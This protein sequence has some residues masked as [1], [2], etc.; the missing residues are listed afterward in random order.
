MHSHI[1][2]NLLSSNRHLAMSLVIHCE[3]L[4][5]TFYDVNIPN[6]LQCTIKILKEVYDMIKP[7]VEQILVNS[8]VGLQHGSSEQGGQC[9]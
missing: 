6:R 7:G 4:M 3:S 8:M 5:G 9:K 1:Y 2:Y